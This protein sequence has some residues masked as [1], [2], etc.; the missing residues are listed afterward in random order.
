MAY[1]GD[2]L[3]GYT[4]FVGSNILAQ[5]TFG[6]LYNSQNIQDIQNQNFRLV[7]CAGAPGTKWIAN[8]NPEQDLAAIKKL[9]SSLEK[10]QCQKLLLISTID[11]YAQPVKRADEDTAIRPEALTPYGRHRRLLEEF[12]EKNFDCLI[13]RLPGHF[14]PGAEKKCDL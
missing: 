2:A 14:W 6:S 3:I 1:S 9:I 7:V 11:V 4:G 8:K 10:V 5:H 12:A 13:V